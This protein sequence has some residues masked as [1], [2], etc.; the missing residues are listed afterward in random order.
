M[1][2]KKKPGA[3]RI[4][5]FTLTLTL[6]LSCISISGCG[7][8]NPEALS[9][10]WSADSEAAESLRSYVS[11]VTD[12]KNGADYIPEEDRIAVFD[13]DGT[14]ICETYYTYYD[15]MMFINYCL[16][17]HPER[18]SDEL[19]AAAAEI[20]PGYTAGEV[21]YVEPEKET[22]GVDGEAAQNNIIQFPGTTA[23]TAYDELQE[24]YEQQGAA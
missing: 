5:S 16:E 1:I 14:L 7:R 21:Q 2:I 10:Y 17:E 22:D 20:N 8:K 9:E 18:V 15:T 19:K 6:L 11:K 12:K 24:N 3:T 4:I 23:A 13:M